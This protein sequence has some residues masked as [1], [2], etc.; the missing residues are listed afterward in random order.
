MKIVKKRG[1]ALEYFLALP[2]KKISNPLSFDL[3]KEQLKST[4]P[5]FIN[6]G[7]IGNK[8]LVDLIVKRV[9][10]DS[11]FFVSE[12]L[13]EIIESY[14]PSERYKKHNNSDKTNKMDKT[15]KANKTNEISKKLQMHPLFVTNN[16]NSLQVAYWCLEMKATEDVVVNKFRDA[17]DMQINESRVIDKAIHKIHYEKQTFL[18]VNHY[19][20]ESILRRC[21]KGIYFQVVKKSEEAK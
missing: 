3:T 12:E 4:K 18:L 1:I 19:L 13:K 15:D 17:Q 5:M 14:E 2:D 8:A 10:F 21:P 6:V 11:Y 16:D 20:A 9:L 7:N